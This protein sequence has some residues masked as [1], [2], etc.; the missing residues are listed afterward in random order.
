MAFRSEKNPAYT[1]DGRL[2]SGL[3]GGR[4][5]IITARLDVN[6][7]KVWKSEVD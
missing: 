6:L 5:Q 1:P 2:R 4:T 3:S 7:E